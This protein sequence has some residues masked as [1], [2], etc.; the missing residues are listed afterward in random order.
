M[1]PVAW[2]KFGA[3]IALGLFVAWMV[4][5]W[6]GFFENEDLALGLMVAMTFFIAWL[7][8]RRTA[9]K[10]RSSQGLQGRDRAP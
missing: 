8:D 4:R 3:V 9:R 7:M 2:L 1:D 6:V 5:T 10:A